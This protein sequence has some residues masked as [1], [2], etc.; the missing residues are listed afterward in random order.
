M[1][2][3]IILSVIKIKIQFEVLNYYLTLFCNGKFTANK[4]TFEIIF[5]C[6]AI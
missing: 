5:H 1:A 6:N 3:D 4:M 2:L